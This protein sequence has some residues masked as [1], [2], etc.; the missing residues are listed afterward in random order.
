MTKTTLV[1]GVDDQGEQ[2]LEY[3]SC[4]KQKNHPGDV[5]S[6]SYK[7]EARIMLALVTPCVP[8]RHITSMCL[9]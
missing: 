2:Y 5:D 8:S 1:H 9:N 3:A 4:E 7:P 6:L